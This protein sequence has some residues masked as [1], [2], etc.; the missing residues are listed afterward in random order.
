MEEGAIALR[1]TSGSPTVAMMGDCNVAL[2]DAAGQCVLVGRTVP[3]HATSCIATV[4]YVRAEY[5]DNPGFGP[6]DLFLSNDPYIS[7]PHQNCIVVV[8]PI[9]A[10]DALLGW[11]GAGIHVGDMGGPIPGQCAVGAQSIWEEPSRLPPIRLVERGVIRK[12][13]EADFL[14]R[15]RTPVNNAMDVRAIIAASTTISARLGELVGRYGLDTVQAA[16]ARVLAVGEARL[17]AILRALPDGEWA[18]KGYL[19]YEDRG[20]RA[21]Y[22]IR[23]TLVKQGETLAFDFGG[24]SEQAPAVINAS[25]TA[26]RARTISTL[27][28]LFSW[29]IGF[30]PAPLE[31]LVQVTAPPGTIVNCSFPA[32][33]SKGTTSA[34]QVVQQLVARAVS[35]MLS[36]SDEY[37][38]RAFMVRGI[39]PTIDVS[40]LDQLGRPYSGVLPYIGQACGSGARYGR[41]GLDTGGRAEP[42]D[43]LPNVETTELRYPV[44]FLYQRE[45]QDT[46]G[47]GAFRGGAGPET[48]FLPHDVPSIPNL[49]FHMHG[50]LSPSALGVF[51]GYPAFNEVTVLR[52][53]N[54]R[55]LLDRGVVPATPA[56]L[57]A[58]IEGARESPPLFGYS[59]LGPDDVCVVV[60]GGGGG[61]GDPLERDVACVARDVQN[62]RVTEAWAARTYGVAIAHGE[63]D[64]AATSELR[65]ALREQRRARAIRPAPRVSEPA[66]YPG[67]GEHIARINDQLQVVRVVGTLA[68]RCA[69]GSLLGAP[70]LYRD[71]LAR[72]EVACR[73]RHP[74]ALRF[75]AD[76]PL[77]FRELYC[78]HCFTLLDLELIPTGTSGVRVVDPPEGSGP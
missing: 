67:A 77:R 75:V 37:R 3:D 11:A 62:G 64:A 50:V 57:E 61:Y 60:G 65:R 14:A 70:D 35:R 51:G 40:G 7:T 28:A 78:P 56:E 12:D 74:Y 24:S 1:E 48:A 59:Y 33:T 39:A 27:R 71:G 45:A 31:R 46:A 49:L 30:S 26:L 29:A 44:L 42:D 47:A 2:L 76:P 68:V 10:A 9:Y 38:H 32:G 4:R 53:S 17:R 55:K 69:C 43:A 52:D 16:L 18:E 21:L 13:V 36:T 41:D 19:D 72:A 15:T 25:L 23:L 5:A 73:E 8:G 54:V 63:V 66:A 6:G 22:T 58:R 20:K 34:V